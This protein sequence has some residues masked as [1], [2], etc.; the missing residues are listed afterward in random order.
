M[1]RRNGIKKRQKVMTIAEKINISVPDELLSTDKEE[2]SNKETLRQELIT[3]KRQYIA[4]IKLG[5]M[6]SCI[7]DE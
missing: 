6:I 4:K 1:K 5:K 2:T 7:I 3:E